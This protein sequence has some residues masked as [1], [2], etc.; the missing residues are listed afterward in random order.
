MNTEKKEI[1]RIE[2]PFYSNIAK[3]VLDAVLGQFSDGMWENSRAMDRYWRFADVT[4]DPDGRVV[5]EVKTKRFIYENTGRGSCRETRNGFADMTDG[6]VLEF[7]AGKAKRV[8]QQELKDENIEKG[9]RR[10]NTGFRTGYL[11]YNEEIT[12]ADVYAIYDRLMNR[13]AAEKYDGRI[14]AEVYGRPKDRTETKAEEQKRARLE[15][16]D[17]E[18]TEARQTLETLKKEAIAKVEANFS[19]DID[20]L[21]KKMA[22]MRDAIRTA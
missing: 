5:I 9:W 3:E 20:R 22:A 13:P 7:F 8:M 2:T 17:I 12:V 15:K 14:L 19:A 6:Q 10:D 16:L 1:R 4:T 21:N 11:N 18:W